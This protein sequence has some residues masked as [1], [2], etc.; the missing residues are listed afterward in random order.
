MIK[1]NDTFDVTSGYWIRKNERIRS[2]RDQLSRALINVLSVHSGGTRPAY[3]TLDV[4]EL[5]TCKMRHFS[6]E[7]GYM[8]VVQVCSPDL[9]CGKTIH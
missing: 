6:L 2:K 5:H 7:F 9:L 1:S 4:R 8:V 3:H